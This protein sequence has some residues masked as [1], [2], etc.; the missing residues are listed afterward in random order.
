M[1]VSPNYNCNIVDVAYRDLPLS[2]ERIDFWQVRLRYHP[3]L[4]MGDLRMI[5]KDEQSGWFYYVRANEKE[6]SVGIGC[7]NPNGSRR[8]SKCGHIHRSTFVRKVN[9]KA[10]QDYAVDTGMVGLPQALQ[11]EHCEEAWTEAFERV[12]YY[13]DD[14]EKRSKTIGI[15]DLIHL[16]APMVL[17]S[18][19]MI[20]TPESRILSKLDEGFGFANS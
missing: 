6:E 9:E 11:K 14:A 20:L 1:V 13:M 4:L 17:P 18:K 7:Y 2:Q 12:E 5:L 19:A 16:I 8:V 3:M 10:R 15:L